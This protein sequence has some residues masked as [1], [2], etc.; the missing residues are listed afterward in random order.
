MTSSFTSCLCLLIVV[1]AILGSYSTSV[2]QAR[3]LT[4]N[5]EQVISSLTVTEESLLQK[6]VG[7]NCWMNLGNQHS[8][9]PYER[10]PP[11]EGPKPGTPKI[12]SFWSW[13]ISKIGGYES[14]TNVGDEYI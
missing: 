11:S 12:S 7:N 2:A 1:S 9:D 3:P 10:P 14:S 13:I 5:W 8:D 6:V 4:G